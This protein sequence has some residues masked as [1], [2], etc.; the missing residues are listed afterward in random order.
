[1]V[2]K[3]MRRM[4][5]LGAL[6]ALTG[7][8]HAEDESFDVMEYVVEGNTVLPAMAI[9]Q[10]V[11]PHLGEGRSMKDIEAA[12]L[13]LERAYRD[14]GYLTVYVDVPEQNVA[15]GEV[16]LKVSE[17]QVERL[18]VTGSNY[19]SLNRIKE[20][21]PALAEGSVPLFPEVQT[22]LAA[23]SRSSDLR[24][25]PVLRA[26]RTPGKVEV[27]LKVEDRSPLHGSV[28]LNDRYSANTTHTRLNAS[29]RY[30]NLWQRGHSITFGAQTAPENTDES[31]V[32]SSTYVWP[33]ENGDYLAAYGVFSNSDV[34]AV[35]DINVIGDGKIGGLRYIRPLRPG[36]GFFHSLTLG[37]DYKDFGET[38]VLQG[39][40]SFNTPI[41][42]LPFALG[43]EASMQDEG[44]L[45]QLG[46]TLNFSL[47]GLADETVECTPGVFLNEFACKRSGGS[48]NYVYLKL[49]AKHTR[50]LKNGWSLFSRASGQ[51][52]G[53]PLISN[54]QFTAGGVDSV[55]GYLE[56][57]SSGDDGIALGA[58]LRAPSLAKRLS[59]KLNDFTP[60]VFAEGASLRVLE[61]LGGQTDRF[62]L[63][64]AGL[65]VRFKGWGG[66]T[67]ALDLAWPFEDAGQTE[68][69]DGR[70]HFRL[71]YEW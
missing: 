10:A 8:A 7:G 17:G 40:D 44:R 24:V 14:A 13:A 34:A 9:E 47:R 19:F 48:A 15:N 28:E 38:L 55:R 57:N 18:R 43:Y 4:I 23:V 1:M 27:D 36:K 35:G 39:A 22:Q 12:R 11:Y 50:A 26:G 65:G 5:L 52:A 21:V 67:G 62:D 71:G 33:M 54:E 49:D 59:P 46:A 25:T 37:V 29:L 32:L 69:G 56:S 64:A 61:P 66:A 2:E 31:Q 6:L 51:L 68:A 53:G 41:S 45:T 30:D 3:M 70:L 42:Y 58:E 16:R 63:L 20:K 60:Y